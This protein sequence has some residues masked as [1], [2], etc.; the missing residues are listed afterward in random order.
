M[1]ECYAAL[2]TTEAPKILVF[3]IT[4]IAIFVYLDGDNVLAGH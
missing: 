3:K 4:A 2:Y 1:K